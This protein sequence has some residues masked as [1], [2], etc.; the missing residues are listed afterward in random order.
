LYL[1]TGEIK[2][3]KTRWLSRLIESLE[4]AGVSCHG[5]LSPGIWRESDNI[6]GNVVFEKLGIEAVLLP[7]DIRF[8]FAKRRDLIEADGGKDEGWQSNKAGLGWVIPDEAI[9]AV[10]RHFDALSEQPSP[11]SKPPS[12]LSH[13][14]PSP[15]SQSPLSQPPLS[16]PLLSTQQPSPLS[17]QPGLLVVD[18]LGILELRGGGGFVSAVRLLERGSCELFEHALVVVRRELL[19]AAIQ[20]FS[21][22]WDEVSVI[23]ADEDSRDLVLRAFEER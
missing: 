1:L 19:D 4:A 15:L 13:P 8:P 21:G 6:D 16:H 14:Q 9:D 20:R 5:L 12:P 11:R 2:T 10:N 22:V 18:E 17:Q 7:D 23:V 3:G